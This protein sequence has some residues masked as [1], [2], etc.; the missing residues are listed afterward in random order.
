MIG[1]DYFS[2]LFRN[3]KEAY[4]VLSDKNNKAKYDNLTQTYKI[5]QSVR[6]KA[7]KIRSGNYN[8]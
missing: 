7:T 2:D 4:D 3:I 8:V 5:G 6:T 1:D